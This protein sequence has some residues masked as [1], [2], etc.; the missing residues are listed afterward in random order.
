MVGT[1]DYVLRP[2]NTVAAAYTV[3]EQLSKGVELFTVEDLANDLQADIAYA[4]EH[5]GV[6]GGGAEAAQ[7][8]AAPQ[9][10]STVAWYCWHWAASPCWLSG[11]MGWCWFAGS[12]ARTEICF[13]PCH[14]RLKEARAT[15]GMGIR[16]GCCLTG[17][18]GNRTAAHRSG[19]ME[20][21]KGEAPIWIG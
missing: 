2:D 14:A 15:E 12:D 20:R 4:K 18:R 10:P 16:V 9:G 19:T 13:C 3:P 11:L 1:S 7:A 5:P 21:R 8:T 17:A 6:L